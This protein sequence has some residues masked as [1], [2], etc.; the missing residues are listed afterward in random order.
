MIN[1]ARFPQREE[2]GLPLRYLAGFYRRQRRLM[3]VL[4]VIFST[5]TLLF[6]YSF[7]DRYTAATL[8]LPE[9][10]GLQASD[11]KGNRL[12]ADTEVEIMRSDAMYRKVAIILSLAK[13]AKPGPNETNARIKPPKDTP[14]AGLSTA[15]LGGVAEAGTARPIEVTADTGN[16]N[17]NIEVTPRMTKALK[18]KIKVRKRGD[19]EV[20]AVEATGNSPEEAAALSCIFTRVCMAEQLRSKLQFIEETERML[21]ERAASPRKQD[22]SSGAGKAAGSDAGTAGRDFYRQYLTRSKLVELNRNAVLPDIRVATWAV[23][24]DT[25]SLPQRKLLAIAGVL[26]SILAAAAIALV[27]DVSFTGISTS[28]ELE[29]ASGVWNIGLVTGAKRRGT[30]G[31]GGKPQDWIIDQPSSPFSRSIHKLYNGAALQ[32]RQRQAVPSIMVTGMSE[33]IPHDVIAVALARSAALGGK[34]VVIVGGE[35]QESRLPLL[36]SLKPRKPVNVPEDAVEQ[37]VRDNL[38]TDPKSSLKVLSVKMGGCGWNDGVVH[39]PVF[40]SVLQYL[41]RNFDLAVVVAPSLPHADNVFLQ[42]VPTGLR[43]LLV[44]SG[45]SMTDEVADAVRQL[46]RAGETNVVTALVTL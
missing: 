39:Y 19:S 26:A 33:K 1:E 32:L 21:E 13:D 2:A 34:K 43:L 17:N 4:T 6:A 44:Q 7:H 37:F 15:C 28:R 22:D 35:Q 31:F 36:M 41:E 46:S 45:V 9:Q 42:A 25:P 5:A 30:W 27:V 8:L 29:I 3:M 11:A 16:I 40:T 23:E 10:H 12:S 18:E 20:I 14:Y 38:Q 24:P